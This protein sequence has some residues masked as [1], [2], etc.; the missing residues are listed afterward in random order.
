M[1][2][3]IG[4]RSTRSGADSKLGFWLA[5]GA[6]AGVGVIG[7]VLCLLLGLPAANSTLRETGTADGVVT[8]VLVGNSPSTRS[9]RRHT[10]TNAGITCKVKFKFDANGKTYQS[11]TTG[12]SSENCY[13]NEGDTVAVA[14]N[15]T[16]PDEAALAGEKYLG[17]IL[18][19][20]FLLISLVLLGVGIVLLSLA[21]RAKSASYPPVAPPG[22]LGES[23]QAEYGTMPQSWTGSGDPGWPRP[24]Q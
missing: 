21:R 24:P 22:P 2:S 6:L 20:V 7:V 19:G 8:S 23:S 5:G 11:T 4:S 3:F 16:N 10:T 12:S 14:F 18:P 15:P 9:T 17:W 13:L 1:R